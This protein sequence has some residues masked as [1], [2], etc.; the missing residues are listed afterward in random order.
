MC[1]L[2]PAS[3]N[4]PKFFLYAPQ[5]TSDDIKIPYLEILGGLIIVLLPVCLGMLILNKKPEVAA[6]LEKLASALGAVFILAA[7]VTGSLQNKVANISELYALVI[8]T[9]KLATIASLIFVCVFV[10]N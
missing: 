3:H 2:F 6:K 10:F 8:T 4:E 1:A 7:M 9:S 5:F